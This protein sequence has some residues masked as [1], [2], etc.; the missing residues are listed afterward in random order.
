MQIGIFKAEFKNPHTVIFA[1]FTKYDY[2]IE[3]SL[4]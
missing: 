4:S 1:W 2:D 3:K